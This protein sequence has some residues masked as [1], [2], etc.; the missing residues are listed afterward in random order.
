MC[1]QKQVDRWAVAQCKKLGKDPIIASEKQEA[2]GK[3]K[4]RWDLITPMDLVNVVGLSSF[5]K[6]ACSK[7]F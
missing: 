6:E 4:F 1:I 5:P 7:T 3:C 2:I